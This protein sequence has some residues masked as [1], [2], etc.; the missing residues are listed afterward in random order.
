MVRRRDDGTEIQEYERSDVAKLIAVLRRDILACEP[1][2][3]LGVE[4]ELVKR[5]G[6]SRPTLRQA[7]RVLEH[8]KLIAVR[9][10]WA[11][12]YY[13]RRP[14]DR[15]M[16]Q[17][18]ALNLQVHRCTIPQAI[19]AGA[20][21]LRAVGQAA[22]LSPDLAAR[23]R[24]RSYIE[25]Y[26]AFDFR[27]RP[28]ADFIASEVMMAQRIS[29]L[30]QNPALIFFMNILYEYGVSRTGLRSFKGHPERIEAEILITAK[31]ARAI[32]EGDT[33]IAEIM[34]S[35][36]D[37]MLLSWLVEDDVSNGGDAY[38][39]MPEIAGAQSEKSL[40]GK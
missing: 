15:D 20:A 22:A 12:G 29:D 21:L 7:V 37:E 32:C 26:E 33:Q 16:V 13:A 2:D 28:V 31:L 3:R 6:V 35:R 24:L 4:D 34:M 5:Y 14:S 25:E 11:G 8:E 19:L 18:A 30:A 1:D 17:A 9:R 39:D 40:A 23:E 38:L 36:K 10:G 27:N